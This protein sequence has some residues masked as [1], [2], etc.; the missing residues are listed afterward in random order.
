M[1]TTFTISGGLKAAIPHSKG[2][3]EARHDAK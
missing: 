3:I 1:R 2:T